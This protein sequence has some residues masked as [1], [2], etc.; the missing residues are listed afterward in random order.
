MKCGNARQ[1]VHFYESVVEHFLLAVF[2]VSEESDEGS[3][4]GRH[5]WKAGGEAEIGR[6]DFVNGDG[7]SDGGMRGEK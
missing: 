7:G 2:L 3:N 6:F 1:R 4:G 5:F